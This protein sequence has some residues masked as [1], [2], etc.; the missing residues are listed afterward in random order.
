MHYLQRRDC[1]CPGIIRLGPALIRFRRGGRRIALFLACQYAPPRHTLAN[2][3]Q[4]HPMPTACLAPLDE[5][6]TIEEL[7][8]D[9]YPIYR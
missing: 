6:I 5:T 3:Q 1:P 2:N 7:T 9:P 4:D 8:R